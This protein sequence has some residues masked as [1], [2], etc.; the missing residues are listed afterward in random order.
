MA[1]EYAAIRVQ[2][3]ETMT[4][5]LEQ[6]EPLRVVGQDRRVEHVRVGHDDLAGG[7]DGRAD[8]GGR[9]AVVGGG[10]DRQA[11]GCPPGLPTLQY[12]VLAERLG[13]EQEE[14]P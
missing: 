8:R 13:R 4:W 9:V 6:L 3:V 14:R 10:E 11:G 1:A 5:L 12:L 2:L 7:P